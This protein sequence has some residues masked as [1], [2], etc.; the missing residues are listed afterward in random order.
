VLPGW[1]RVRGEFRERAEGVDNLGFVG[2][3]DDLYYLS[4][5]RLNATASSTHASGTVQFQDAR[6]ARKTIGTTAA[7]FAAPFDLRMAYADLGSAR[8]PI[9]ARVGRQEL[10]YGD[11]R[12]VGHS[13][14]TNAA[15]TFDAVRVRFNTPIARVDVFGASVVRSLD[16]EF[17]KSG[18]GNRFAGTYVTLATLLPRGT[19][20]PYVLWRRDKGQRAESGSIGSLTELTT[21][22]RLAGALPSRLDYNVEMALQ[23][24]SL[25]SDSIDAWAGHW[26]I[27]ESFAGTLAAHISGE[28][29]NASGDADP[30]DRTRGT[31]DQLYA[32]GH[33]KHGLADQV[34]WRNIH[35]LRMGFDLSPLTATPIAVD[36]HSYWLGERRD[37]L[38]GSGGAV[39]ARVASGATSTRVGQEIDLQVLRPLSRQ[40]S[41]AAGYSHLF[42][43]P[44][45]KQATPGESYSGPFVML[46]YVFLAEK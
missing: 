21:G 25:A 14:W 22:V 28:Y 15:R 4:R 33:D 40:L 39:V 26:Q 32:S 7:P 43:G 2:S 16:G 36:Y 13:S 17:D 30:A 1:L 8:G 41:L 44:F 27:R 38:Y 34:G 18:A 42:A 24:G 9:A 3:A 31:F 29:N 37:A 46:T 11:Q 10:A 45:L 12:L 19:V 20:E 23:T 6:V 35:D 5:V